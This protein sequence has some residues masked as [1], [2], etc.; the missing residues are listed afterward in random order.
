MPYLLLFAAGVTLA[1]CCLAPPSWMAALACAVLLGCGPWRR[2]GVWLL[3]LIVGFAWSAWRIEQRLASAW[4]AQWEGRPVM[5][6][7]R[8]VGLPRQDAMA[9][10]L[11][12]VLEHVE[13]SPPLANWPARVGVSDYQR[14]DWPA[15]SRW[16]AQLTLRRWRAASNPH[17]FAAEAWL[18]EQGRLASGSVRPGAQRLADSQHPQAWLDRWRAAAVARVT[19]AAGEHTYSGVLTALI[20][21]EQGYIPPE[22]WR[23]FAQTGLTH[24]VSVSGVHLTLLAGLVASVTIWLWRR[25]TRW[26]APPRL[27]GAVAGLLAASAYGLLAGWSLPTQRSLYF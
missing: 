25:Q 6:T 14:G 16:R 27:A 18:M 3:A 23:L 19:R 24:L 17:T 20:T 8:V 7:L 26:R 15:G 11:D 2:H 4:P 22:H 5:V 9:T 10:R 13:L 21:G 12:A 1:Q